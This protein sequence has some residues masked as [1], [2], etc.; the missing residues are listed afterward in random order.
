MPLRT[1]SVGGPMRLTAGGKLSCACCNCPTTS[2]LCATSSGSHT[3]CGFDAGTVVC[4]PANKIYLILTLSG[5]CTTDPDPSDF[6]CNDTQRSVSASSYGSGPISYDPITCELTNDSVNVPCTEP[7]S[8]AV[9]L[10]ELSDEF[11]TSELI[12][13]VIEEIG[14]VGE[15]APCFG[16][17]SIAAFSL[18]SDELSASGKAGAYAFAIPEGVTGCY[19]ITWDRVSTPSMGSPT[20]TPM[21]YVW[22]G[23]ATQSPTYDEPMPGDAMSTP[24]ESVEI[25][26]ENVI[27]FC[28]GC[29]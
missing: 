26:I 2:F 13:I 4:G 7:G 8:S 19:R 17:D 23:I 21:E 16:T 1:K 24:G 29:V 20:V 6:F 22:D 15:L 12:D 25:T 3:K 14:T 10:S 9:A 28:T 5:F 18:S 27:V 11:T